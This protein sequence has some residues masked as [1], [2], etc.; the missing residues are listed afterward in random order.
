MTKHYLIE[1]LENKTLS[2]DKELHLIIEVSESFSFTSTCLKLKLYSLTT[3]E[4]SNKFL[5]F[6]KARRLLE[7]KKIQHIYKEYKLID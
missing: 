5:K 7:N 2:I 1:A 6:K 3:K 4:F